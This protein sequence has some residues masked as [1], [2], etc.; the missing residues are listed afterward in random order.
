M[1]FIT[2]KREYFESSV[3]YITLDGNKTTDFF[4]DGRSE[5]SNADTYSF[6]KILGY[7]NDGTWKEITES[8]AKKLLKPKRVFEIGDVYTCDNG[9]SKVLIVGLP[10]NYAQEPMFCMTGLCENPGQSY[11]NGLKNR[12]AMQEHLT[13]HNYTYLGKLSF[14]GLTRV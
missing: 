4:K 5:A 7:L 13:G 3:A 11:S 9:T 12:N 14:N 2:H 1:K 8:E 6:E 10:F